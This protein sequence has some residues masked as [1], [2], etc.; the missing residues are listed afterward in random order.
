VFVLDAGSLYEH[1]VSEELES[2]FAEVKVDTD[3][4]ILVVCINK[5][6]LVTNEEKI[7]I[8][9]GMYICVRFAY[10]NKEIKVW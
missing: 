4:Q 9:K 2:L 6:D 5:S 1:S 7:E 3:E 8:E 10:L